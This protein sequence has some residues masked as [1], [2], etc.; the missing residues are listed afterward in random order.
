MVPAGQ[1]R[2]VWQSA[3]RPF[4]QVVPD[5]AGHARRRGRRTCP[6]RCRSAPAAQGFSAHSLR[7]QHLVHAHP[8]GLA[9]AGLALA[10]GRGALA[11]HA[12]GAGRAHGAGVDDAVA[13]V[14][15]AVA[16]L[17]R[18]A[19]AAL[20]DP[21]ARAGADQPP[22]PALAQD[23]AR[24]QA[25]RAA[26]HRRS[27]AGSRRRCRCSCCP[28]RRTPLRSGRRCCRSACPPGTWWCPG[29][30]RPPACRRARPPRAAAP[31][32]S[33]RRSRCRRRRTPRRPPWS[34]RRCRWCRCRPSC[35]P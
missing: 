10:A 26:L 6:R 2:R 7:M 29:G 28:G 20:A 19:D 4:S 13:V 14:V 3:H 30:T 9:A 17:G 1:L 35:T 5:R 11:V 12:G 33:A 18:G 34:S 16:H 32:R 23:R 8:V 21:A 22:R 15:L 25:R 31:R 24:R 27:W